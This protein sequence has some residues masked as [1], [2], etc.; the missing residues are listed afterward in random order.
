MIGFIIQLFTLNKLKINNY[1]KN[2]NINNNN[3]CLGVKFL[4][5][6]YIFSPPTIHIYT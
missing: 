3:N 4:L 6:Q 5:L 2:N 1:K